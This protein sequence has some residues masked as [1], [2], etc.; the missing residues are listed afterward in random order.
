MTSSRMGIVGMVAFV[1]LAGC[2]NSA[3]QDPDEIANA[4]A[5]IQGGQLE[6]GFP[7]VG[8]VVLGD[9]SFCTGT[10]IS[11]SYV[12]T[13][14]HCAGSGMVFKTGTSASNFVSHAVDDQIKHPSLDLLIAHLASPIAGIP[15]MAVNAGDLPSINEVCTAVGFGMHDENGRTTS[16]TK[17]SATEQVTSAS[18]SQIVVHMV[19][20]VADHGDSGGP[21]LCSSGIA[22]VVHNH[23][24]G[25]FPQH[26]VENY[27][28][29]DAAWI[30]RT[31]APPPSQAKTSDI[32]W[33]N[34]NTGQITEWLMSNATVGAVVNLFIEPAQWQV[35]G[36]GDFNGD[37]SSDILFRNVETGEFVQW[38]MSNGQVVGAPAL[39]A[40]PAEWQV[41][42]I[43][44][45]NGDGTSDILWN[46]VKTGEF[47]EWLMSNA[48]VGAVVNLFTEPAEWQVR[49]IGDFNG[50]GTS[51]ILWN[52][53][54]T[55]AFAEWLMSN[56]NVGGVTNLFTEPAEWQVQGIGDFN[57]DGTSDI[58]WNNV[59][60]GEFAE[61]LMS[62]GNVGG[63]MNLFT[64]PA[65]WHVVGI[66]DFNGD[67]TSDVLWTNVNTGEYVQWLM[68]NGGV[69]GVQPLFTEP[70]EW[71]VQGIGN[72]DG[73]H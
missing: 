28:T 12:L 61:W 57:G 66:G 58:L 4:A 44:D 35:Q 67:A 9:G 46:N 30:A 16:G 31:V 45:F 64:E 37:G 60:T 15:L 23:T 56:G 29:V 59:K 21:L 1:S 17:R 62:N 32:L 6:S 71:H 33:R 36:T 50:D 55:G 24:D 39:F 49:G 5:P 13:A 20:G 65:E 42:G 8:Q 7:A 22:A 27:T 52:N 73:Q 68:S 70:A 18:A 63:V 40:E 41:R 25:N 53:V 47:A 11:P 10:L 14:A 34:V 38:L 54:K 48:T 3:S 43:G 26:Q 2:T 72:F 19:S 51:D 69:G